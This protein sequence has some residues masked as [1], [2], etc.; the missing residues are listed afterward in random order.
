MN[1]KVPLINVYYSRGVYSCRILHFLHCSDTICQPCSKP[2]NAVLHASEFETH[3]LKLSDYIY[4]VSFAFDRTV[5][6]LGS[7]QSI[8]HVC[9]HYSKCRFL[10]GIVWSA[11]YILKYFHKAVKYVLAVSAH[12]LSESIEILYTNHLTPLLTSTWSDSFTACWLLAER[13]DRQL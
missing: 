3:S 12:S 5:T 9:R 2:T 10:N 7:L 13:E 1:A 8:W 4:A 6:N 11:D